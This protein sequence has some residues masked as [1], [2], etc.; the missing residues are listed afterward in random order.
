MYLQRLVQ[1]ALRLD[2]ADSDFILVQPGGEL[3]QSLFLRLE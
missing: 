3:S 2:G 1:T